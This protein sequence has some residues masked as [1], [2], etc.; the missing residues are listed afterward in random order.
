[1]R[2]YIVTMQ[3]NE[4]I[5][6]NQQKPS[7]ADRVRLGEVYAAAAVPRSVDPQTHE[8]RQ[9]GIDDQAARYGQGNLTIGPL[10]S[11]E[12]VVDMSSGLDMVYTEMAAR[13]DFLDRQGRSDSEDSQPKDL[14]G[15]PS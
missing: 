3:K 1:M 4:N 10:I 6:S 11:S 7:L 14:V 8:A 5:E 15:T 9:K 2:Y 13:Q 12:G